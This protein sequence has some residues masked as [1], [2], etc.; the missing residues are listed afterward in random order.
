MA[1]EYTNCTSAEG[2]DPS[3]NESPGYDIKHSDGKA[4]VMLELRGMR[5]T[6]SLLSLPGQLWPG[7]VAPDRV[8]SMGYMEQFEI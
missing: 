4:P 1:E 7:L 6:L 3:P 2:K 8:L 5:S